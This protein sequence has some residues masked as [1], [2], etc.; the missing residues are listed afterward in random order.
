[1]RKERGAQGTVRLEGQGRRAGPGHRGHHHSPQDPG[2]TRQCYA[3]LLTVMWRKEHKGA[4]TNS[5][6]P[7]QKPVWSSGRRM[8]MVTVGVGRHED[9]WHLG[10]IDRVGC[11]Q[12]EESKESRRI[13]SN[14]GHLQRLAWGEIKNQCSHDPFR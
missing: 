8:K 12:G 5:Q 7:I 13:H 1:M 11:Q 6:R 3:L 4:E 14:V 10:G 9:V 2:P